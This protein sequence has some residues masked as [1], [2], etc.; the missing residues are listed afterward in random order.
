MFHLYVD[1]V[2]PTEADDI[3]IPSDDLYVRRSGFDVVFLVNGAF[4]LEA[5]ADRLRELLGNSSRIVEV[6]ILSQPVDSQPVQRSPAEG[7]IPLQPARVRAA[8]QPAPPR[9][10]AVEWR[11]EARRAVA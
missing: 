4:L 11:Q 10:G 1:G 7:Q 6:A 5:G 9:A 8:G 3:L 2:G